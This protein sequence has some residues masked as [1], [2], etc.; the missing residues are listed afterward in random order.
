MKCSQC[1]EENKK[2]T[3]SSEGCSTTLLGYGGPFYD[4]DGIYHD[5]DPNIVTT[6]YRC[7]NGHRWHEKG[8]KQCPGCKQKEQ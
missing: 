2:S 8:S 5:H 4:E 7:S 3:V 6:Y 1:I